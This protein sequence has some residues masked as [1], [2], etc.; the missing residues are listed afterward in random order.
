MQTESGKPVAAPRSREA[1]RALRPGDRVEIEHLVTVG[2]RSWKT[3]VRGEVVATDR[4]RHGKHFRRNFDDK[5]F[6]DAIVLRLPDGE[7]TTLTLD[8]FSRIVRSS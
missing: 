3:V 7:L 8:E 6:S 2:R 1:F 5:V 4:T